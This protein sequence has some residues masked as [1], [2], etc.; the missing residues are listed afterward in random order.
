MRR[1]TIGILTMLGLLVLAGEAHALELLPNGKFDAG[2][3][4]W[5]ACCGGT[6]TVSFDAGRDASGSDLSGSAKLVHTE[7]AGQTE[8]AL[9][10]SRCIEG[11]DVQPGKQLFF[12]ATVRFAAR[13]TADGKAYISLEFRDAPACE[14]GSLSGAVDA[15]QSTDVPAA[16][17]IPLAVGDS[18]AGVVVPEGAKSARLFV[19][20]SK[21][22]S[23][24]LRINADDVFLAAVGT[25]VCDGMPA[26][27]VGTPEA[28][29]LPGTTG[30]D[31]I[32][33]RGGVD[34][35]D[36]KAGNDRLCGSGGDDVVYGGLGDDR[37]FGGTGHDQVY[38]GADDDLVVG[39]AGDDD[40][41]GGSG[42]DTLEGGGGIDDCDGGSGAVDLASGCESTIAVP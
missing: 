27:I 11:P 33:G 4:T 42:V 21:A 8:T 19:V 36:G 41:F 22:G 24:T 28:D 26:T 20:A 29:F 3:D 23:G 1:V 34:W 5:F 16:T 37:V 12:G 31:V 30:S 15:V 9:F 17:W 13:N 7:A 2:I 18:K 25:P 39:G 14:G 35:I 40:V 6:G 32:V 10:L 38:G